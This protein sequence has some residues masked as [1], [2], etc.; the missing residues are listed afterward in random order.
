M[1]KRERERKEGTNR[2]DSL[3]QRTAVSSLSRR[4]IPDRAAAACKLF[5]LPPFLLS[6]RVTY[7]SAA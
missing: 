4:P 3:S 2:I 5:A 7:L 6:L 1:R